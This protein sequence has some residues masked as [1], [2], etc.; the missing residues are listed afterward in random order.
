MFNKDRQSTK[1]DQSAITTFDRKEVKNSPAMS[2]AVTSL[3]NHTADK[4]LE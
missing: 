3:E 4:A 2:A 1:E